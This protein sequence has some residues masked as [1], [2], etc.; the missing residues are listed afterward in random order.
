[1]ATYITMEPLWQLGCICS[2]LN[3]DILSHK[4]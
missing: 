3:R 2:N 4:W 1:L